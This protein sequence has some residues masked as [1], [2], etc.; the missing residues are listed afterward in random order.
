MRRCAR[1]CWTKVSFPYC[2]GGVG[3]CTRYIK[4]NIIVKS[5]LRTARW[6]LK[7]I[8]L[9]FA[10]LGREVS[11]L[12]TDPTASIMTSEYS[13]SW[14]AGLICACQQQ[15]SPHV[16]G[17]LGSLHAWMGRVARFGLVLH[18]S[19]ALCRSLPCRLPPYQPVP[20]GNSY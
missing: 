6:S 2:P 4:Y 8:K 17:I 1:S 11:D 18:F 5:G 19:L 15:D 12:R 10:A 3:V 7:T 14:I 16:G 13:A 20:S 9:V